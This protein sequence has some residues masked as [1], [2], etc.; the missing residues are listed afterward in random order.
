[1]TEHLTSPTA[2]AAD[3]P[4]VVTLNWEGDQ[5]R[6]VH[7]A[8]HWSDQ[9]NPTTLLDQVCRAYRAAP[10]GIPNWRLQVTLGAVELEDLKEFTH[11]LREARKSD[12]VDRSEPQWTC[13]EHLRSQWTAGG[14]LVHIEDPDSWLWNANRQDLCDELTAVAQRPEH[15]G[16]EATPGVNRLMAF[17]GKKGSQ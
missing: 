16:G 14:Q 17:I 13:S 3:Q 8:P 12:P 5:V 11:L 15:S 10:A 6:S 4:I 2:D 1:M 9:V 7:V